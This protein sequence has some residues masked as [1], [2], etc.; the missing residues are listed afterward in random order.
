MY[1]LRPK[2][3]FGHE[4]SLL[5]LTAYISPPFL[6]SLVARFTLAVLLVTQTC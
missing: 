6:N 2:E 4:L 3:S 5:R 1:W